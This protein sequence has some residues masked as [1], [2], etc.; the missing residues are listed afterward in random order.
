VDGARRDLPETITH[1]PR[2][3]MMNIY[4]RFAWPDVCSEVQKLKVSIREGQALEGDFRG[5]ATDLATSQENRAKSLRK[6]CD[7][8]GSL[9]NLR[10]EI[11]LSL[12]ALRAA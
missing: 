8:S 5:L 2:G 9:S 1:G 4:T 12:V 10:L 11:P 6:K 7:P 3:D